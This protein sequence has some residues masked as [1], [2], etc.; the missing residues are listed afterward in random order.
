MC[1]VY[2]FEAGAKR[3]NCRQLFNIKI[4][5]VLTTVLVVLKHCNGSCLFHIL[6]CLAFWA[7]LLVSCSQ[8]LLC[9]QFKFMFEIIQLNICSCRICTKVAEQPPKILDRFF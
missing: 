7:K 9:K 1:F 5:L 8:N 4:R 2:T 6:N 3:E